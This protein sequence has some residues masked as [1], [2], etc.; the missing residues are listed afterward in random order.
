MTTEISTLAVAEAAIA[1]VAPAE[2]APAEAATPT[3]QPV[4]TKPVTWETDRNAAAAA[5]MRAGATPREVRVLASLGAQ[6]AAALRLTA[7]KGAADSTK[8]DDRAAESVLAAHRAAAS[9]TWNI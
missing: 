7:R 8:V 5:L 3:P 1:E 9:P 2:A 4:K 6:A